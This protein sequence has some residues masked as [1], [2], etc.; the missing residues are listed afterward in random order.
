MARLSR[1]AR[2]HLKRR[3]MNTAPLAVHPWPGSRPPIRPL[4]NPLVISIRTPDTTIRHEAR[5]RIRQALCEVL[6]GL[7]DC[8]ADAVHLIAER[9]RPL[10][11]DLAEQRIGLS[12][13]H[14]SGLT[15]A[16]IY[17]EQRVGIDLIRV[18]NQPNWL[19]DWKD[20]ARAYLGEQATGR[21]SR[22][23]PPQQPHAFAH[24]W[25]RFEA[26]LKCLGLALAETSP[27]L[28]RSLSQCRVIGLD[29]PEGLVGKVATL[30]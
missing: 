29:L 9:G 26:C 7:L 3:R 17:P 21:I 25:A 16:A 23:L 5:I 12:V 20:V 2:T 6:G 30:L 28:R 8:P 27:A 4:R 11:L 18:P 14:E 15:L 22:L 24:E 13:S 1:R 10:Q 19:P